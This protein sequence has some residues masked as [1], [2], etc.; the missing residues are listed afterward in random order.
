MVLPN[1]YERT[2]KWYMVRYKLIKS[3]RKWVL[4]H[5]EPA[6]TRAHVPYSSTVN[7]QSIPANTPKLKLKRTKSIECNT[8]TSNESLHKKLHEDHWRVQLVDCMTELT[9]ALSGVEIAKERKTRISRT[10]QIAKYADKMANS[11]KRNLNPSQI[12]NHDED[13]EEIRNYSIV[14]SKETNATD[15]KITLRISDNQ[16]KNDLATS[17]TL[18]RKRVANGTIP[19]KNQSSPPKSRKSSAS[20]D[21]SSKKH[22]PKSA[23]N[24]CL[25][26]ASI[27][28]QTTTQM[29]TVDESIGARRTPRK[30]EFE[31]R[32]EYEN[33]TPE[34]GGSTKTKQIRTGSIKATIDSRP[35]SGE[36]VSNDL[37]IAREKLHV[38]A[39]PRSLPCR[40]K[41]YDI[42]F[43][44]LEGKIYDGSGGCMYVSGVPGTGKTATTTAVIN[45][46]KM[47]SEAEEI[48]KFQF[49]DI[50]G[51]RLTE[52][53]QAYVQIYRQ[54]TGKTLAWEQAYNLLNKRF[55]TKAPRRITTVLLI[56]ELDII[57]NRR[58]DVVYNLLN[59]PTLETAQLIVVTI[60]NTMDLPERVLMGKISSRLGLTRLTFQPY[61]FRQLQEIVLARLAGTNAFNN[62]AVQL[63]SRKVAAV[64]GDARRALDICRRATE[65]CDSSGSI[66]SMAHVQTVLAEMIA[67]PQV[68][69]IRSCSRIEQMFLHAVTIEVTRIGIEECCFLGVYNQLETLC[70]F[71]GISVPNPGRAMMICARLGAFRLLICENSSSDIYQ[72]ILLNINADDVHYALQNNNDL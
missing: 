2:N 6:P 63:V 13:N 11:P 56:D 57:C 62:D 29:I 66:V 31:K 12:L 64:S 54:L 42:L 7:E 24:K 26:A 70:A 44:F 5:L 59:W 22:M 46:L 61:N 23:N 34:R 4:Q 35:M 58:Q 55:T 69:T 41:E 30:L 68:K 48:P 65:L 32:K 45:S 25:E 27:P 14:K 39:T 47:M 51:M 19:L 37:S 8:N 3:G 53:R 43:N 52:P 38:A 1:E 9:N 21:R 60:A 67:S 50:N 71:A 72:K 18:A 15:M 49:V 10:S 33:L 28:A 17:S 40:E 36:S 16:T 20:L